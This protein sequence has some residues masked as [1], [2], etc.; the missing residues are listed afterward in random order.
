[1]DTSHQ[2]FSIETE[3]A[4]AHETELVAS[5]FATDSTAAVPQGPKIGA[6]FSRPGNRAGG[7]P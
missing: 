4:F 2:L 6:S 7:R 3:T 5:V 1:V